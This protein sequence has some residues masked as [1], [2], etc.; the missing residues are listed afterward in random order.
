MTRYE[1]ATRTSNHD[2]NVRVRLKERVRFRL[3]GLKVRGTASPCAR[4]TI[5]PYENLVGREILDVFRNGRLTAGPPLVVTM[6][7]SRT[8]GVF[9]RGIREA[10]TCRNKSARLTLRDAKDAVLSSRSK[11]RR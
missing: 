3:S 11:P 9:D 5:L 1:L 4:K 10:I 6:I 8:G 7:N 2:I